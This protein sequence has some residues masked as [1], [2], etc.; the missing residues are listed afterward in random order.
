MKTLILTL[1]FAFSLFAQ[2]DWSE[3]VQLSEV[4]IPREISYYNPVI[5]SKSDT[6]SVFWIKNIY[7]ST[8]S[9]VC[10]QLERKW[11]YDGGI[12]W[13]DTENTTPEYTVYSNDN[14]WKLKAVC[15][16]ENNVYVFYMKGL[17]FDT[18]SVIYKR[19][20]GVE[21]SKP[22]TLTSLASNDLQ[23]VIDKEDRIYVFWSRNG[24]QYYT[25]SDK[26]ED[27]MWIEPLTFENSNTNTTIINSNFIFD[28]ENNLYVTGN[29]TGDFKGLRPGLFSYDRSEERWNDIEEIGS[30]TSTSSGCGLVLLSDSTI[31][32]NVSV[33]QYIDEGYNYV[34]S[35]KL[36]A[37][38]WAQPVY[39]N[40]NTDIYT[41]KMFN[42][43]VD[44]IHLIEQ[45]IIDRRAEL[46][47]SYTKGN[48]WHAETVQADA[49][50][51]FGYVDAA[52]RYGSDK[53]FLVF[54]VYD[55]LNS[56]ATCNYFQ[57]K[58]IDTGIE[59]DG[60][61]IPKEITLYQNYPNP[62]NNSTNISYSIPQ[63]SEVKLSVYNTKG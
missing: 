38:I 43:S 17:G 40:Q 8:V 9:L 48:V 55:R 6:I 37:A 44:N 63:T 15:D 34:V 41:K 26:N 49:N 61:N 21:W 16:S 23:A 42:D 57:T 22:D 60:S 51:T 27:R 45:Y 4:G 58:Q 33:G 31:V 59:D 2:Y 14:I 12:S 50:E 62:F 35:R 5:T 54:T 53:I 1:T 52:F 20:N 36:N 28:E 25:Y 56:N 29:L 24:Y 39:L 3:P 13:S 7:N 18:N 10:T 32:A 19:F 30:F 47:Y 11:S 46:I